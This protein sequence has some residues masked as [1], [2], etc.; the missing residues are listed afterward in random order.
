[1]EIKD[2]MDF[3]LEKIIEY[4]GDDDSFKDMTS[5]DDNYNADPDP[6]E[7][8]DKVNA[9]GTDETLER[10][11]VKISENTVAYYPLN[12]P[13][14]YVFFCNDHHMVMKNHNITIDGHRYFDYCYKNWDNNS[15]NSKFMIDGNEFADFTR[16]GTNYISINGFMCEKPEV[17]NDVQ[18]KKLYDEL[19]SAFSKSCKIDEYDIEQYNIVFDPKASYEDKIL[20]MEDDHYYIE[21]FYEHIADDGKRT[22]FYDD[23]ICLEY[24]DDDN[25]E[26]LFIGGYDCIQQ[27]FSGYVLVKYTDANGKSVIEINGNGLS[28]YDE[29][30]RH[31]VRINGYEL[32]TYEENGK[33]VGFINGVKCRNDTEAA[34]ENNLPDDKHT[35]ANKKPR[36]NV[37][38]DNYVNYDDD[39]DPN[40]LPF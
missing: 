38:F 33:T 17:K 40:D 31:I 26:V 36:K 21:R 29:N 1:M 2:M 15:I 30:G 19:W 5:D 27:Y 25:K 16:N 13:E 39:V 11:K 6:D 22:I 7:F 18:C 10:F 20:N 9:L 35:E 34:E 8:A 28:E 14:D 37:S 4:D 32:V 23:N 12:E 24:T 3:E